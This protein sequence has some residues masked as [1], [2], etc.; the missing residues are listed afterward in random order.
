M[1]LKLYNTLTRS[2]EPVR[3]IDPDL[4]RVYVCGPTV[5]NHPTS[6]TPRPTSPST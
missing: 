2:V 3:P 1:A 4:V 6:D 5:Y